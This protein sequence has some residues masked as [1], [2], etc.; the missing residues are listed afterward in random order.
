MALSHNQMLSAGG[1]EHH[2]TGG[3][4]SG[5]GQYLTVALN[6]WCWGCGV[7]WG[8][9]A[10]GARYGCLD[11]CA[12]HGLRGVCECWSCCCEGVE[13]CLV[14]YTR[15]VCLD[16]CCGTCLQVLWACGKALASYALAGSLSRILCKVTM[17]GSFWSGRPTMTCP[18]GWVGCKAGPARVASLQHRAI[19]MRGPDPVVCACDTHLGVFG[20]SV[21]S[22]R[23]CLSLQRLV[24]TSPCT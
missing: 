17:D 15:Q 8:G 7:F 9:V 1:V 24:W 6:W 21:H 10:G 19:C 12:G 13:W 18:A 11:V 2:T 16:R 20:P 23:L 3:C 14:D 22:A 4:C 5:G